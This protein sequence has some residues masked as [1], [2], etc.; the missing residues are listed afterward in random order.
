M[1]KLKKLIRENGMT[2]VELAKMLNVQPS[3]ITAWIHATYEP[4]PSRYEK[5]AK[6][7]GLSSRK[8]LVDIINRN[9]RDVHGR[10]AV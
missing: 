2:Q 10:D 9:R 5:L 1:T 8:E 4:H 3:V 7:L 6:I